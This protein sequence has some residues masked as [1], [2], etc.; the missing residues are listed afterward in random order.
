MPEPPLPPGVPL[1]DAD[2]ALSCEF[3]LH[4]GYCCENGCRNCPY[5][6]R[7]DPAN[8]PLERRSDAETPDRT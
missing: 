6:F 7:P 8:E 5:D 4:R 1:F 3:L 2:G